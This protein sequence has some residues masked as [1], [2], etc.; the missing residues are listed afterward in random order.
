MLF[1]YQITPLPTNIVHNHAGIPE[2]PASAA[3]IFE[4]WE[5]RSGTAFRTR[6]PQTLV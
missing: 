3:M 4:N 1:W 2:C 6:E 5:L